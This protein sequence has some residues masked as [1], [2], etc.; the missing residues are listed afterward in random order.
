[1]LPAALSKALLLFFIAALERVSATTQFPFRATTD[2]ERSNFVNSPVGS[3]GDSK[4]YQFKWPIRKV[5]IIGAGVS[6]LLA[7]R[8]LVGAGFEQVKIFE[9]DALPGGIWHYT[10]ETPAEAP[11][12]NE[13]PKIADYEPSLPPSGTVMPFEKCM[14]TAERWRRHR[15]PHG[16]WKSLTSNVPAPFMHF[17]GLP[18]PPGTPWRLTQTLLTNYIRSAY[19]FFGINSND[20]NPNTSY[21]TRVELVEKRFDADGNEHGW[22]L[23]LKRFI[24][25]GSSSSKEQWWA[26]DFDAVVVATGTFNAP[27]IPNIP[28]LAEWS[29]RFPG[30]ILHSREYRHPEKFAD[31]SV[32]IVG[33]GVRCPGYNQLS[34]IFNRELVRPAQREY[35]R[36]STPSSS[37]TFSLF[38]AA[39]VDLSDGTFLSDIDHI[40]FSTG[41]QY[42]FPFLPQYHNSSIGP[43]EEA[44]EGCTQP[45]VTDGSHYRS[46]YRDFIYIEEPTLGFVN[47]N[48]NT[49]SWYFGEYFAIALAKIWSSTAMLP[50]QEEMWKSYHLAVAARGGYGKGLVFSDFREYITF[51]SAWLNSAAFEFG[52]RL[53]NGLDPE[54]GEIIKTFV[55]ALFA[56]S[57]P[58][59]IPSNH[60]DGFT[61]TSAGDELDPFHALNYLTGTY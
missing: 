8:E 19:S 25:L 56:N 54:F 53:V 21:S 57:N 35:Q 45:V 34:S 40:I 43:N 18:F 22:R 10:D 52:G 14:T 58:V 9:R 1:M 15:A 60:T 17:T 47:M 3:I 28:G 27:N 5:A 55:T 42:T 32:L 41:Y 4:F 39:Q 23:T 20:E 33:A 24:R 48:Y 30:S 13:D 16:V 49:V 38:G 50:N 51:F 36:T 37:G 12:P 6:G 26:E 29:Q 7:Y 46:L 31:K 11:I 2:A 59:Q 44:P 61:S